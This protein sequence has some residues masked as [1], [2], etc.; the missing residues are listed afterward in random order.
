[1]EE[2]LEKLW[3]DYLSD[4]CAAINTEKER[5]LTESTALLCD[6]LQ[7]LLNS[8][9]KEALEKYIDSL[10]DINCIF[11]K[12]AFITGCKFTANFLLG[13]IITK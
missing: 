3:N 7:V 2:I 5:K 10:S 12:K 13:V 8:D 6:N 1:M 4:E 9:Q 11:A